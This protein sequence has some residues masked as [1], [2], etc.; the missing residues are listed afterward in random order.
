MN[1]SSLHTTAISM[2]KDSNVK[3]HLNNIT[4]QIYLFLIILIQ[5]NVTH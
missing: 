3:S 4:G 2:K 5:S 1:D